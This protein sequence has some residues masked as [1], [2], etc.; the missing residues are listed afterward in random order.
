MSLWELLEVGVLQFLM[1]TDNISFVAIIRS[2]IILVFL[3]LY[4]FG[5]SGCMSDTT[6]QAYEDQKK[7][8]ERVFLKDLKFCRQFASQNLK[9]GEGSE[10][11]GER[12]IRKRS[13]F[14]LCMKNHNWIL[15]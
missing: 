4:G 1:A 2:G 5:A 11:A 6:Y 14:L 3:G 15:K 7:K 9:P 12:E 13:I 10:G 8:G